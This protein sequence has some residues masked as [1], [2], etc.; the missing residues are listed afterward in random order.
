MLQHNGAMFRDVW[1]WKG[2]ILGGTISFC[3][4][5]VDQAVG[6]D[7]IHRPMSS[8]DVAQWCSSLL[9]EDDNDYSWLITESMTLF[10][11]P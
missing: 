11:W 8:L 7:G 2:W 9:S 5:D 1:F 4:V 6:W 3:C 10:P